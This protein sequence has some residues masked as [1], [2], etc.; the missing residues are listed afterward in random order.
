MAS[1]Y[2]LGH[3]FRFV[4]RINHMPGGL[5]IAQRQETHLSRIADDAMEQTP[6]PFKRGRKTRRIA[7]M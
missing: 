5:I 3:S 4:V 1:V 6:D 2:G 7:S